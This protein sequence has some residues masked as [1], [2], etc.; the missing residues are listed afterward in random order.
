M[1][2]K[3][4]NNYIVD[5]NKG[6]AKIELRRRGKPSLWTT[7]DLEDLERVLNFKYTWFSKYYKDIDNYYA[8]ATEYLYCDNGKS[9]NRL[10]Y[11]HQFILNANG[12]IVDHKNHNTLDNTRKNIEIVEDRYNSTNRKTRNKNNKSGYRNVC[13]SKSENKWIVQLF[14]KGKNICLGKFPYN[15][16]EQAGKFAEEMRLKY[17][18]KFAGKN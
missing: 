12:K 5:E 17:Y 4:G 11:L 10:I 8:C 13:W 3:K 9:K 6:I 14:I 16:L 7:I 2:N 18:G 1:A 15:E